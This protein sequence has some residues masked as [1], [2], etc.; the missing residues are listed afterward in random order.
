MRTVVSNITI[1]NSNYINYEFNPN[2]DYQLCGSPQEII[3]GRLPILLEDGT[4]VSIQNPA[5]NLD[6]FESKVTNIFNV[7]VLD[8]EIQ[9]EWW[10]SGEKLVY[11][12]QTSLFDD[13]S[14]ISACNDLPSVPELGDEP[15]FAKLSDGTWLMF[16][17]RL[18]LQSNTLES[19][20]VDGGKQIQEASGGDTYC[21]NVPRTFLNEKQCQLSTDACTSNSNSAIDITLDNSTIPILHNLTGR[22]VYAIKGQLVK[23]DGIVLDHPC[24]PGLRS[25]WEPKNLTECDFTP[26]F[27]DTNSSLFSLLSSSNDRN[28]YIRDIYFPNEGMYCNVTD[29]EPEIEIEVNGLCW[30][31]VHDEYMS[32]FDV[33]VFFYL[34]IVTRN[35]SQKIFT[36]ISFLLFR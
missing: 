19:P 2:F 4:C 5:I 15:I 34:Y 14:L 27:S 3:N 12:L 31:R 26:L 10:T 30:T 11:N 33:S 1:E 8:M 21:A 16:D 7:D 29:T 36:K 18:S 22:Y 9:D 32:V 17:P 23:Y 24:T 13:D 6:G 25:R 28:P 20:I 35:K